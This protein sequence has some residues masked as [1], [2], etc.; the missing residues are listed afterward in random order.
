ML[1]HE[2]TSKPRQNCGRWVMV[3]WLTEGWI[4][5]LSWQGTPMKNSHK[6]NLDRFHSPS[7]ILSGVFWRGYSSLSCLRGVHSWKKR[8]SCTCYGGGKEHQP[9]RLSLLRRRA[10]AVSRGALGSDQGTDPSVY[11]LCVHS[12]HSDMK[13][14]CNLSWSTAR[15]G[16]PF[17]ASSE[18]R[19][20]SRGRD[21]SDVYVWSLNWRLTTVSSK[22]EFGPVMAAGP[23]TLPSPLE[24]QQG[25]SVNR[26]AQVPPLLGGFAKAHAK[27]WPTTATSALP[28]KGLLSTSQLLWICSFPPKKPFLFIPTNNQVTHGQGITPSATHILLPV[29]SLTYMYHLCSQPRQV[30]FAHPQGS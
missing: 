11:L 13:H 3:F 20:H 29:Y 16:P 4:P 24:S 30:L 17:G 7:L 26:G 10:H 5:L 25:C 22:W 28:E 27:L 8:A 1:V 9:C 12:C 19:I 21:D 2:D 18:Q 6:E 23:Q 14:V 15:Q